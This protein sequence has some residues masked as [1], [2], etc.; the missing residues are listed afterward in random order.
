MQAMYGA[1]QV[2]QYVVSAP[3]LPAG[4]SESSWHIVHCGVGLP[5]PPEHG[6]VPASPFGEH[7]LRT[8]LL[9]VW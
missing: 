1:L 6:P 4:L 2:P 8:Q 9:R 5:P 3:Q 7:S